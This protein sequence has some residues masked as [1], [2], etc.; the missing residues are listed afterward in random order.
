[1]KEDKDSPIILGHPLHNIEQALVDICDSKLTL[2]A[3]NDEMKFGVEDEFKKDCAQNEVF[4][5]DEENE[6]EELEKLMEEEIQTREQAKRTKP[7]AS[8]PMFFE[9]LAYKTPNSFVS[10]ESLVS[11][12]EKP[13]I[14]QDMRKPTL[15]KE[16]VEAKELQKEKGEFV[17][18]QNKGVKRK[19]EED[20]SKM[21]K[22]N[23]KKAYLRRVQAYK[24]RLTEQKVHME[25]VPPTN[26]R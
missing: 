12:D 1:M 4:F 10:E 26:T 6:L 5:M 21:K 19:H 25:I 8:I 16:D 11:S 17:L 15:D 23:S 3:G 20:D 2:R 22:E 14:T 7:R 9:V 18:V 13:E 24:K